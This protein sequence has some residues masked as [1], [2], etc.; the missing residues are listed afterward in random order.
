[1]NFSSPTYLYTFYNARF[2]VV[3]VKKLLKYFQNW[4]IK[5]KKT[6]NVCIIFLLVVT[7][8]VPLPERCCEINN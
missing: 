5:G 1:M 6:Q 7:F 4:W 2:K 8:S 3:E